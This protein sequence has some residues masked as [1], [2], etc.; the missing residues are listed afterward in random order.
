MGC[1]AGLR[2]DGGAVEFLHQAAY[3][4]WEFGE[5]VEVEVGVV[6]VVVSKTEKEKVG[7]SKD[8]GVMCLCTTCKH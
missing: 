8:V 4:A 1:R 3:A 7:I 5:E 2:D 6:C